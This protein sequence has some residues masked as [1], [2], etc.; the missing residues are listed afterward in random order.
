MKDRKT[1]QLTL[2]NSGLTDLSMTL[3]VSISLSDA[4]ISLLRKLVGILP[5]AADFCL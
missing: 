4:P 3:A 2:G 5:A 1:T